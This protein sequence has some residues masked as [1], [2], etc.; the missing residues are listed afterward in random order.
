MIDLPADSA[1]LQLEAVGPKT[2][3][4]AVFWDNTL[5]ADAYKVRLLLSLAG[6]TNAG[7]DTRIVDIF[8]GRDHDTAAFRALSPMG[9]LPVWQE[10]LQ[11]ASQAESDDV[12][13]SSPDQVREE[14]L[15]LFG[16]ESIMAYLAT[17]HT[18]AFAVGSGEQIDAAACAGWLIFAAGALSTVLEARKRA[19]FGDPEGELPFLQR[20]GLEALEALDDVLGERGLEDRTWLVGA[21]PTVADIACYPAHAMAR[22]AGLDPNRFHALTIWARRIRALPGFI[23]MPGIPD[24]A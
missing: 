4:A 15:T 1:G 19:V 2:T 9:E 11:K 8:P 12:N 16:A 20:R 14:V 13:G 21:R 6:I 22:E 18:P 3:L 7:I 10:V 24:F 23:T 5:D 17:T